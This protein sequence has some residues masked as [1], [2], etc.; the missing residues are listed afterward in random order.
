M[1]A[2]GGAAAPRGGGAENLKRR[3]LLGAEVQ[4]AARDHRDVA[5]RAAVGA[6]ER[7]RDVALEVVR[8][9]ERVGRVAVLGVGGDP[10]QLA[11]VGVLARRALELELVARA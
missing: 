3:G 5:D 9:Q 7:E 10:Q 8:A 11:R 1:G 4:A 2:T 6:P